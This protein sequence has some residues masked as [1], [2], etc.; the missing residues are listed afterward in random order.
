MNKTQLVC[1]FLGLLLV[2]AV[3]FPMSAQAGVGVTP[4]SL[5][6][7]SVVV[8]TTSPVATIFVTN[9]G[10]ETVSISQIS[11]SLAEFVVISPS[12]PITLGPHGSASFQVV[13]Q[14]DAALTFNGSIVLRASHRG[15]GTETISVSGTG[16]TRPPAPS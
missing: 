6:F 7:G 12:M 4:T 2:S 11:S 9:S 1:L 8:D 5:S 3:F 14:P 13:F 16:T 15:G 10:R